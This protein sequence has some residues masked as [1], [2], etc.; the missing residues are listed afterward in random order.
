[1][2]L[3]GRRLIFE[4]RLSAGIMQKIIIF[5]EQLLFRFIDVWEFV[6]EDIFSD[7]IVRE[8]IN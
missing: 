4:S 7:L 3:F 1:M 6:F 8:E 2:I 5:E